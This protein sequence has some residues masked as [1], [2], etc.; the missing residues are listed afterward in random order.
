M[1]SQDDSQD[2]GREPEN[3]ET[4][5]S[6]ETGGPPGEPAHEASLP[7]EILAADIGPS[8]KRKKEKKP[9]GLGGLIFLLVLILVGGA[10]A[11][12][13]YLYQEQVK[14]KKELFARI[15]QLEARLNAL[16]TEADLT[17]KNKENLDV[18]NQDLQQFKTEIAATLK[19]HQNSLATLDEDVLRLKEKLTEGEAPAP[20]A[21]EI[22]EPG[23]LL[24]PGSSE[25][26]DEDLP[27]SDSQK[28]PSEK[29]ASGEKSKPFLDWMEN[30]F[31]AIWNWFAGLFK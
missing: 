6:D 9:S 1:S 17:R 15:S 27:P 30:F 26:R 5:A 22:G 28:E 4:P 3:E 13:F 14:F 25:S 7:P 2:P 10:G 20:P 29:D 23:L 16:D 18:L 31:A 8:R 19:A 12:G 11:G 21:S 24:L